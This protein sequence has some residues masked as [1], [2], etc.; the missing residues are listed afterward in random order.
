M[1]HCS[2]RSPFKRSAKMR[3][4]GCPAPRQACQFAKGLTLYGLEPTYEF[5]TEQALGFGAPER[6]DHNNKYDPG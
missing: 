4:F 6:P 5:S 2:F 3:A 1:F